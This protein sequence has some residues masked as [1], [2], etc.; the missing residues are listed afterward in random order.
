MTVAAPRADVL[1]TLDV[2]RYLAHQ[3]ALR[4]QLLDHGTQESLL[5]LGELL[6]LGIRIDLGFQNQPG[7]HRPSDAS[8]RRQCNL[9][10]FRAR[11]NDTGDTDHKKLM[12]NVKCKMYNDRRL[13]E[14]D[15]GRGEN[16]G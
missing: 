2:E 4:Q 7:R 3:V 12:Q 15:A 14:N 8:D 16:Q 6:C 1:Q 9:Y 5:R 11:E 13:R 10:A